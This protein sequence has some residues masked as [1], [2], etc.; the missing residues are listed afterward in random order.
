MPQMNIIVALLH[1]GEIKHF[2]WMLLIMILV[3]INNIV[4]IVL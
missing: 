2:D 1:C 4:Y 3:F